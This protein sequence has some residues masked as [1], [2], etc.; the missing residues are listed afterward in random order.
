MESS[1]STSSTLKVFFFLFA[2]GM[3]V[4]DIA[5]HGRLIFLE[6]ENWN[7]YSNCFDII[8]DILKKMNI[9]LDNT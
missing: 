4:V 1:G 7:P 2:A 5:Y 6:R 3:G 8:E 9:S